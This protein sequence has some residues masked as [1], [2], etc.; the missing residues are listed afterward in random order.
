MADTNRKLS[1]RPRSS[2]DPF[3]F[4][5]LAQLLITLIGLIGIWFQYRERPE[6]FTLGHTL[7]I[8]AWLSPFIFCGCSLLV[9]LWRKIRRR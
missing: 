2:L 6:D 7:L 3:R 5:V 1:N 4:L 8:L 9:E